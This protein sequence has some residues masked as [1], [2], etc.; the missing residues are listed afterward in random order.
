M[1]TKEQSRIALNGLLRRYNENKQDK[2]YIKNERRICDNLIRPF[3]NLVLGWDVETEFKS[4]YVQGGKRVDY[5][6]VL[7][8]ISQFA[9]EAKALI[10][11]VRGDNQYYQQ[12]IQYAQYKEKKFAIH[13]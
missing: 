2:D 13:K 5:L 3:F 7:D 8:G 12:A 4:E 10:H 1:V 9:I 11:D 6:V